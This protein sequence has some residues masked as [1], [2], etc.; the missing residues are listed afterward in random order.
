MKEQG[1]EY[2]GSWGITEKEAGY[3][4]LAPGPG[5]QTNLTG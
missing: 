1:P 5:E 4:V 3:V 2:G